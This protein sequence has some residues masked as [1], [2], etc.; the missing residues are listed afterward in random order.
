MK[1]YFF[2]INQ[3]QIEKFFLN[4]KDTFNNFSIHTDANFLK[5][6]LR[7]LNELFKMIGGQISSKDNIPKETDFPESKKY[8]SLLRDISFDLQ[9]LFNTQKIIQSDVTNLLNFNSAQ[10]TKTQENLT[11]LQQE[12]YSLF[13]KN[14]KGI[15]KEIVVPANNPFTS[16]DNMSQDSTGVSIDQSRGILTL[17]SSTKIFKPID[18][19][20]TS[21]YFFD[22]IPE[23]EIYPNNIVMGVGSHWSVPGR[24]DVHFIGNNLTDIENY[25]SLMV[26]TPDENTGIGWSEF[27]AVRT[28][29]DEDS[30]SELKNLIAT[31]FTTSESNIYLDKT[32][33]LQGKYLSSSRPQEM[34]RNKYKLI[35]YFTPDI[36]LTNEI[37]FDFEPS[38]NGNYPIIDYDSSKIFSNDAGTELVRTFIKPSTDHLITEN[39]EYKCVIKEGFIVPTRLELVLQYQGDILHWVPIPFI[40]SHY[41]Y[42]AQ[43]NYTLKDELDR[44]ISILLNKTYDIFVDSEYDQESE[45]SRAINVLLAK[46]NENVNVDGGG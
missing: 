39:G 33:S 8:N 38:D 19:K 24:A 11:S 2:K 23:P 17:E 12:I 15:G 22:N 31:R 36:G 32:N 42:T 44:D 4:I 28:L 43:K 45:K 34:Q 40:M 46:K 9:K 37:Y 13:I 26:D 1:N 21:I 7:N 29:V 5:S 35:I 14:K 3:K 20:K 10:R 30:L 41:S 18:V 27:E 6:I 25:K 16:S